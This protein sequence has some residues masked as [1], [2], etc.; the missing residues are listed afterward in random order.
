MMI[1]KGNAGDDKPTR[2]ENE[3]MESF[4]VCNP[5]NGTYPLSL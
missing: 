5:R 3:I 2:G 4:G 1:G